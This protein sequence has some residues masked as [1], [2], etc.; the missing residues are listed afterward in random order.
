VDG[1]AS[2]I[3][4]G[5][6]LANI[7]SIYRGAHV[8]EVDIYHLS[9]CRAELGL[10]MERRYWDSLFA[11]LQILVNEN[12]VYSTPFLIG[13]IPRHCVG[14]LRV[15]NLSGECVCAATAFDNNGTCEVIRQYTARKDTY[16]IGAL[17]ALGMP[18]TALVAVQH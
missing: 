3:G 7:T 1:S 16:T 17:T 11:V 10:H 18:R 13:V 9:S 12:P 5:V 14:E 6:Y 2:H 8:V 4:G 15:P